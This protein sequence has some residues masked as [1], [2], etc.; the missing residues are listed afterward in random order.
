[1][2]CVRFAFYCAKMYSHHFFPLGGFGLNT[3]STPG[4]QKTLSCQR[5]LPVMNDAF[6]SLRACA[7][8]SITLTV[9]K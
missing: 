9:V 8:M 1:M 3:L 4:H 7:V 2:A 6:H 5:A